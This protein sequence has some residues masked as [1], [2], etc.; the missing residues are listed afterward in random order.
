[1]SEFRFLFNRSPSGW[2]SENKIAILYENIKSANPDD[3]FS[4]VIMK[5]LIRK[6]SP[7]FRT[8]GDGEIQVTKRQDRTNRSN[9]KDSMLRVDCSVLLKY[10]LSSAHI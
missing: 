2:D 9:A 8:T 3:S 7:E 4:E 5:P 10:S 1:M 6:V